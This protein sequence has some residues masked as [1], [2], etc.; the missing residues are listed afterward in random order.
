MKWRWRKYQERHTVLILRKT[1]DLLMAMTPESFPIPRLLILPQIIYRCLMIAGTLGWAPTPINEA[2]LRGAA[3]PGDA[4][5]MSWYGTS[6]WTGE[7]PSPSSNARVLGEIPQL[8]LGKCAAR[9]WFCFLLFQPLGPTLSLFLP[10][11]TF[12]C[13]LEMTILASASSSL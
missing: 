9:F 8:C 7:I 3:F 4:V 5:V 11:T 6:V 12:H 13:D 1:S 2:Y 10:F